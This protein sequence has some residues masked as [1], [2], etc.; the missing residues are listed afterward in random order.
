MKLVKKVA[1]TLLG[2]TM[3]FSFGACDFLGIGGKTDSSDSNG[4]ENSSPDGNDGATGEGVKYLDGIVKS[5][6]EANTL[7]INVD[8]VND[9]NYVES[10]GNYADCTNADI[11]L[12]LAKVNDS[13][14]VYFNALVENVYGEETYT[15]TVEAYIIS[16]A[17]YVLEDGE[18]EGSGWTKQAFNW[19]TALGLNDVEAG[20]EGAPAATTMI[21]QMLGQLATGDTTALYNAL[22]VI[23]EQTV[24]IDIKNQTY[25]FELDL[26]N[27]I[28][29]GIE[30]LNN[31]DL[32][33]SVTA[34]VD[35][36]LENV[37]AD[38]TVKDILEEV[39]TSGTVTVQ[40]IY[41]TLN[42]AIQENA[43]MDIDGLKNEVLNKLDLSM[44]ETMIDAETF[45]EISQMITTL[46]ETKVSELLADYMAVTVDDLLAMY[47]GEGATT[48]TLAAQIEAMLTDMTIGNVLDMICAEMGENYDYETDTYIPYTF[49]DVLA[50]INGLDL[51]TLKEDVGVQFNGYG[52]KKVTYGFEMD[53]TYTAAYYTQTIKNSQLVTIVASDEITSL[54]A[55]TDYELIEGDFSFVAK[56]KVTVI[57]CAKC[58]AE[59][60]YCEDL[61][62]DCYEEVYNLAGICDI[63]ESNEANV[64]SSG[65]E[66]CEEC[67]NDFYAE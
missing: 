27:P 57:M 67:F 15:D 26:A 5:L 9:V 42:T 38:V 17:I 11:T 64:D 66:I 19:E 14:N 61:C 34:Y 29:A 56:D 7:T 31:L 24:L 10:D 13:Y 60:I 18:E 25:N 30:Y 63:C 20:T 65:S 52:V 32:T 3:A 50:A 37:N 62:Y 12:Q 54:I 1:A 59:Y 43:N 8:V 51:R 44:Y 4:W 40:N 6:K 47:M 35:G 53:A 21:Q 2:L 28:N 39:A 55:P 46:K 23:F 45:A 36:I 49:Q 48:E 16:D 33:Q 41:N 58:G 22:G